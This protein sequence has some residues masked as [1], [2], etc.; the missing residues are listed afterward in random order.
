ME[1]GRRIGS[2]VSLRCFARRPFVLEWMR[3]GLKTIA[4]GIA[5][6][7]LCGRFAFDSVVLLL[8]RQIR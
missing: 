1:A 6:L 8:Q 2:L 7:R 3:V 4:K 5:R